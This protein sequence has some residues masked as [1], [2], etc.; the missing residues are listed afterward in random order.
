MHFGQVGPF[1]VF[2]APVGAP[3]MNGMIGKIMHSLGAM[4]AAS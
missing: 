4:L 3:A 1:F 2:Q